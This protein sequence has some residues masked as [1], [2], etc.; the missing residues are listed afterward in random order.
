MHYSLSSSSSIIHSFHIFLSFLKNQTY[1]FFK[2]YIYR[3]F[4]LFFW[5]Y[6]SA[7]LF[8]MVWYVM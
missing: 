2:V 4:F 7:L 3:F 8:R 6:S 5:F 1:V